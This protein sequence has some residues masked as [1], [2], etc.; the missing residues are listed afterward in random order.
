MATASGDNDSY[1]Q[2]EKEYHTIVTDHDL[3]IRVIECKDVERLQGEGATQRLVADRVAEK[4]HK[5]EVKRDVLLKASAYFGTLLGNSHFQEAGQS[6]VDLFDDVGVA[7]EVWFKIL[8]NASLD[9]TQT[10]VDIRGVWEVLV[11]AHK[12][13]LDPKMPEAKKWFEG[14]YMKHNVKAVS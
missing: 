3:V 10:T 14:W 4:V 5:F 12:Y 7:V 2:L 8:H 9:S 6:I 13:G 1:W 11:A